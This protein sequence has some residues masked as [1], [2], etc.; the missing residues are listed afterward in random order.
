MG[1]SD[2]DYM[3]ADRP[4]RRR[5]STAPGWWSRLRFFLWRLLHRR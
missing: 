2:R 3:Q 4:K 1:L 5:R